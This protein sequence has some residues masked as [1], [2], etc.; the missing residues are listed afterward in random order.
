[1]SQEQP[2]KESFE[3]FE[4]RLN[5]GAEK[6]AEKGAP[7]NPFGIKAG[8]RQKGDTSAIWR[9]LGSPPGEIPA[10]TEAA[11]L[12]EN[13]IDVVERLKKDGYEYIL[14]RGSPS[15]LV[16]YQGHEKEQFRIVCL[17]DE[18]HRIFLIFEKKKGWFKR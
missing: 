14:Q 5:E 2:Q 6:G 1:M 4:Q 3:E 13:T 17:G 11:L 12:K 16:S 15:Q 9:E 7:N 18:M 8:A 10:G